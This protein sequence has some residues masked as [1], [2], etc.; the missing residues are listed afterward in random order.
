MAAALVHRGPD[1]GAVEVY[2]R[3]ALGVRRLRV[4]DLSTGSQPVTSEDGSVVAV[5]NGEIYTFPELRRE[6]EARGHRVPGTG[7][8]P[9][10]P[11]LYEEYGPS[12]PDRLSGMFAAAVWDGRRE[13]LVLARDR[14]GKKPL[15]YTQLPDG[16]L[17]FASQVKAL[18]RLPGVSRRPHPAAVDA[19]LA[20]GYV[21]GGTGI[22][23]IHKLPPGHVLTAEKGRVTVERYARLRPL[24]PLSDREW[25]ELVR[26]R[27]SAAVRRRLIS[28][29]PLGALLSGG[30]DSTVV[31]AAMA[32][33][34]ARPVRTFTVGFAHDRYDER[35]YA[36]T[37]ADRYG[38][39]HEEVVVETDVADTLPRLAAAFDEPHGDDA[40][41]PLFLVCQAAKRRVTVA[42]TGDGGDEAFCGYERYRACQLAGRAALP[43]VGVAG[44]ALRLLGG[45]RRSW[46][47]RAARFLEAAGA[48]PKAARNNPKTGT[49]G[50][51]MAE[52]AA[53]K[54]ARAAEP[55]AE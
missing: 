24:G 50:K 20:L 40:A 43:G 31:V 17:A 11:H 21:P 9:V 25:L 26:E 27:V 6:L 46:P 19:F 53:K 33:A 14:V 5:F 37:V 48:R 1:E 54:A 22:V 28:D 10:I 32:Q 15:V 13:R 49:P 51:A 36:R 8:T 16:S 4:I 2:G 23:G 30:L 42:L 45:E 12:F 39:E 35:A 18:L 44:R 34:S 29:V 38:T 3:C 47:A 41:L 55:A 7:D 52:R